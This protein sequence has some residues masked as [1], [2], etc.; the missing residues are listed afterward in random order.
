MATIAT[1]EVWA[2]ED[3][4]GVPVGKCWKTELEAKKRLKVTAIWRVD[5]QGTKHENLLA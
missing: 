4:A 2:L 3:G 1:G 5:I